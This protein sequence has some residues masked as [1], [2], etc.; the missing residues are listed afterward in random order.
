MLSCVIE[1]SSLKYLS[2]DKTSLVSQTQ[3]H[4]FSFAIIIFF[5]ILS[6]ILSLSLALCNNIDFVFF[7]ESSIGNIRNVLSVINIRIS[8]RSNKIDTYNMN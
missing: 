8:V 7:G 2:G 6:Q 4:K 5:L 3:L 1:F